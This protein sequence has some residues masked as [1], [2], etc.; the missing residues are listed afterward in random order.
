MLAVKSTSKAF[1]IHFIV[2]LTG[3]SRWKREEMG[4]ACGTYRGEDRGIK[5]FGGE[6]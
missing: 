2:Y 1:T 6:A 3:T 4:G 5:I